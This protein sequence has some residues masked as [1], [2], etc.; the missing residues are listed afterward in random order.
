MNLSRV[1]YL[2]TC[3]HVLFSFSIMLSPFISAL[4]H[5]LH[6]NSNVDIF[7]F[8]GLLQHCIWLPLGLIPYCC[9]HYWES[10]EVGEE[11]HQKRHGLNCADGLWEIKPAGRNCSF[12]SLQVVSAPGKEDNRSVAKSKKGKCAIQKKKQ[13]MQTKEQSVIFILEI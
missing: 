3:L 13:A 8:S 6:Y 10:E 5:L 2:A 9:G 12:Y 4:I 11:C 7:S 1:Q